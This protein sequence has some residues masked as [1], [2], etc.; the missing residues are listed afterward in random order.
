[1]HKMGW[2]TLFNWKNLPY[3]LNYP[4]AVFKGLEREGHD[5]SYCYVSKPHR[6][7]TGEG[8]DDWFIRSE[9]YVFAIYMFDSLEIFSWKFEKTD[10]VNFDFPERFESRYAQKVW[11][12]H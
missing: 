8:D 5:E 7:W 9:G 10:D 4:V 12:T 2:K 3:G 6:V 1:M 11:P